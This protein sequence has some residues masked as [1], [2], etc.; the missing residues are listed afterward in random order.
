MLILWTSAVL[1]LN[2][3]TQQHVFTLAS[4]VMLAL[5]VYVAVT[6]PVDA[7]Q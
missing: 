6:D 3:F 1:L 7:E 5:A 2:V 4:L